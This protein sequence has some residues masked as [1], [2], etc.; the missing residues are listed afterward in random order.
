MV[1]PCWPRVEFCV[2]CVCVCANVRED[3]E[4]NGCAR[5][6]VCAVEEIAHFKNTDSNPAPFKPALSQIPQTGSS[7][8][9]THNCRI[10]AFRRCLA[11]DSPSSPASGTVPAS[12]LSPSHPH[13]WS[14][15]Y[16][17]AQYSGPRWQGAIMAAREAVTT[18]DQTRLDQGRTPPPDQSPARAVTP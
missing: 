7:L 9:L 11:S 12:Q 2:S 10:V 5:A 8:F 18:H 16:S 4:W 1:N 3:A 13:H 17:T 6:S 14:D 15:P